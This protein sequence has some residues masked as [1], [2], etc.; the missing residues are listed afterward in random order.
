MIPNRPGALVRGSN[1]GRQKLVNLTD[2]E[3]GNSNQIPSLTFGLSDCGRVREANQDQFLIAELVKS[4]LVSA[5]TLELGERVFGRVQGEILLV[6]DG[7]GGHAAGEQASQLA[8][9]HLVHRLLNSVHWF[10]HGDDGNE[11]DFVANLQD[12]MQDANAKIL[13]ESA[14]NSK[15]R[16]MGTTLTMAHRIGRRMFVVHAGDSRCYLYRNGAVEQLTTDHTLA[17]QM[18]EKGGMRPE[19][20]STSRWSNVLWNVLGG[21]SNDEVVAEARRVD[22]EE[23]DLIVLCSDGLHRYVDAEMLAEVLSVTEDPESACR[24]LI[25]L[26]NSSGGQDN[27]TVVVAKPDLSVATKRTFLPEAAP[28]LASNR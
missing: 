20:E 19:D 3:M 10:F 6:A 14:R 9:S 15:V 13:R 2:D 26:A 17:R 28:K 11:D 1:D 8:I 24:T 25:D 16:G 22:L 21:N 12:L 7:M 18:V 23:G 5:T 4:M 27:V